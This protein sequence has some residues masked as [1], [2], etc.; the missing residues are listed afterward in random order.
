VSCLA[1]SS[2]NTRL[3]SGVTILLSLLLSLL[4]SSSLFSL[5]SLLSLLLSLIQILQG[6]D[7]S[8]Y[9]WDVATGRILRRFS[10]HAARIDGVAV[11]GISDSVCLSGSYDGTVKIW[12][13]K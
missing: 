6:G 4:L 9:V 5:L 11:G 3:F 12:D 13:L 2:D 8:L 10:G 7:K 1:I